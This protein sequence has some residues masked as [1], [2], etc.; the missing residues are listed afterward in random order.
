MKK[1][2]SILMLLVVSFSLSAC[3]NSKVDASVISTYLENL[4][5]GNFEKA[6]LQLETVPENFNYGDNE[7]MKNLFAKMNYEVKSTDVKGSEVKA[8]VYLSLPNTSL[9]YDGMMNTIGDDIQKLQ[10][11]S[12]SDKSKASDMMVAYLLKKINEE[13]VKRVEN[14]IEVTLKIVD[15]KT[16]IVPNEDLSK[17]L[18]GI[19]VAK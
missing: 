9:I 3:Q 5:T 4:K 16:V 15:G 19:L 13:Q 11:G 18:S 6:K 7:I 2:I 8:T 1:L 10:A 17:A 14:T 12:D